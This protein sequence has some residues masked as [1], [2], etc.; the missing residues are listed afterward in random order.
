[1]D[2][3]DHLFGDTLAQEENEGE[4]P[5]DDE[6]PADDVGGDGNDD[7]TG[8]PPQPIKLEPKK[9]TVRNPRNMLN[10]AKLSG[11]RG[12]IGLQDHFKDFRFRGKGYELAD[13]DSMMRRYEHWAHRL[14][15]K[16]HFDDC[17]ATIEKLG[18]KKI[19]QAYMNKYRTGLLQQEIDEAAAN[20]S[21]DDDD[22]DEGVV[23]HRFN[24]PLDPLDSMLDEQIAISRG[25]TSLGNTS[26][27]ADISMDTT[28]DTI[29]KD[30]GLQDGNSSVGPK[31]VP[32]ESSVSVSDE[33]KA[34]IEEN[35]K[36]ALEIRKARQLA[37]A[38]DVTGK[39]NVEAVSGENDGSFL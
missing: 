10:A 29:R 25:R 8:G 9:K 16:Y 18:N 2:H 4:I 24:L 3:Y 13:L 37:Q 23:N 33:L 21:D 19:V 35:R 5:S 31:V 34:K 27:I 11:P 22:G 39:E 36:R 6:L 28:F 20:R 15:P 32:P 30:K 26:G 7:G 14:Y 17:V 1:M 38:Q 12:I